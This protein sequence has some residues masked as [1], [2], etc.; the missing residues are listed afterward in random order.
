M[1]LD[2]RRTSE[3]YSPLL[4]TICLSMVVVN[5]ITTTIFVIC[6]YKEYRVWKN[7]KNG[8]GLCYRDIPS[9]IYKIGIKGFVKCTKNKA[10]Q[11]LNDHQ[12][13]FK[14]QY[15]AHHILTGE[16]YINIFLKHLCVNIFWDFPMRYKGDS[17]AHMFPKKI[18][19]FCQQNRRIFWE[20]CSE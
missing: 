15:V 20:S 14:N 9:K 2:T 7:I 13:P 12:L 17:C 5:H 6:S 3:N 19:S 18:L 1:S 8:I 16:D 10:K 4:R 11:V